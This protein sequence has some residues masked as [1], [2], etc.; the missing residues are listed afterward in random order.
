L[1]GL[2]ITTDHLVPI[3][4]QGAPTTITVT[5]GSTLNYSASA[6][7]TVQ[8]TIT[9]GSS[10]TFSSPAWV[11]STGLS[12]ITVQSSYPGPI[13]QGQ[14][15][16]FVVNATA[17]ASGQPQT[18]A[19]LPVTN[20]NGLRRW[21]A[22]LAD[23][24]NAEAPIVCVGDSHTFG[25]NA[26]G[27]DSSPNTSTAADGT[28]GYVGQLRSLF[29]GVY[30]DPGEGLWLP[31]NSYDSRVTLGGAPT[32]FASPGQAPFLMRYNMRLTSA[33]KTIT[34]TVPTGATRMMVVQ[35]NQAGN[36]SSTWSLNGSNQGAITTLTNTGVPTLTY[37]TVVAGQPVVLTGP[38]S[39]N[40]T[41]LALGFRTTQ[42]SG[43]PCHRIGVSGQTLW[44]MLGGVYNGV[45]GTFD[46]SNFY[47]TV[48]QTAN[49]QAC[50]QWAGSKGLLLLYTGTNE[51]S[52]QLGTAGLGNGVTPAIMAAGVQFAVNQAVADGWCC[53]LVG[54]PPSASENVSAGAQPLTA[55][56]SALRSIAAST[57]HCAMVDIADLWGGNTSAA[58]TATSNAGLRNSGDSHPTR[59]GYGDIARAIHRVLTAA[60]PTGN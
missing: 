18:V 31:S 1:S 14:L 34:V 37:L 58:K 57:D 11:W 48:Q 35:A 27:T 21:R 13:S 3:G 51:Q 54:P 56:T 45:T 25:Q 7:K 29:A 38:A 49:V 39:G 2:E 5:S 32:S 19:G 26:D 15:P 60:V 4:L 6:S 28:L 44:T 59:A 24:F 10:Y 20:L 36:N 43:V 47:S 42:T 46:G 41:F 22:A 9:N 53:L 52:L 33:S 17:T 40:D 30:G 8:G 23:A 16:S 12:E 55:Y 50:Y